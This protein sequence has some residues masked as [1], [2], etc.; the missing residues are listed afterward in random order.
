MDELKKNLIGKD[1]KE[2]KGKNPEGDCAYYH[3]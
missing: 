3:L 1:T 2:E